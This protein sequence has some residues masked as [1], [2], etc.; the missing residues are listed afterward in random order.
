M[1]V[2][3][4]FLNGELDEHVYMKFPLGYRGFR[5]KISAQSTTQST[6]SL[7]C[8]L[9]KALYRLKQAPHQWFNKLSSVL[10]QLGYTQ[11]QIDHNLFVKNSGASITLIL[12]YVDDILICRNSPGEIQT[13]KVMLSN[14]F[15]MKDLGQVNYFLGLEISRSLAG[16]FIFQRKYTLDLIKNMECAMLLLSRF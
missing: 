10:M 13:I 8:K 9:L 1:D 15:H 6:I 16:F 3:N 11:S 2:S 7:V 12:V 4:A 14:Q 5:T